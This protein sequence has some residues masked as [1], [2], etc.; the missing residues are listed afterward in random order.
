[1]SYRPNFANFTTISHVH[2]LRTLRQSDTSTL[3]W[4][5]WMW[6]TITNAALWLIEPDRPCYLWVID[7]RETERHWLQQSEEYKSIKV[8]WWTSN[9]IEKQNLGFDF[10]GNVH[11]ETCTRRETVCT[12]NSNR[13]GATLFQLSRGDL[14]DLTNWIAAF[15][16]TT[17]LNS[18]LQRSRHI[19]ACKHERNRAHLLY[20]I[21][22]SWTQ[23]LFTNSFLDSHGNANYRIYWR[24]PSLSPLEAESYTPTERGA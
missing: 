13:C 14:F 23:D 19:I 2:A 6:K 20:M 9:E 22:A 21:C 8:W 11:D 3:W 12:N 1:M 24:I 16:V 4:I 15:I 10:H 18:S 17:S 7:R 5:H